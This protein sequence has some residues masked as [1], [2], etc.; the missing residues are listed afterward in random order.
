MARMVPS[1]RSAVTAILKKQQSRCGRSGYLLKQGTINRAWKERWFVLPGHGAVLLIYEQGTSVLPRSVVQFASVSSGVEEVPSTG[2][3]FEV[4][5]VPAKN[6]GLDKLES[7]AARKLNTLMRKLSSAATS[8]SESL[9]R[10][11]G[12]WA[13]FWSVTSAARSSDE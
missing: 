12:S 4:W 3:S 7:P 5:G 10:R 2:F 6:Q 11:S 13:H 8:A 1:G 9:R